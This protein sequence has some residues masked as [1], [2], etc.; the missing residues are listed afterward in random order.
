MRSI[1]WN[2]LAV[3]MSSPK[4]TGPER[5]MVGRCLDLIIRIN[6]KTRSQDWR[7]GKIRKVLKV[8]QRHAFKAGYAYHSQ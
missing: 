1:V 3:K 6:Y 4:Y 7:I 5:R 8:L 2:V